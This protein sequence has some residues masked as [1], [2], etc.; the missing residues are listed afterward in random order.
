MFRYLRKFIEA[1]LQKKMVFLGGPRQ[2]GKTTLA[3][4]LGTSDDEYFNWDNDEQRKAILAKRWKA[5]ASLII[6]DELHKYPHWKSWIK[7]VWDVKTS[8]QRFLVTGSA[9]LDVYQKSGDSLVGRYHYWRLHPFTL[10]EYPEG[11]SQ[12][13]VYERLLK[14]GGFPEPFLSGDEREAR[15]WRRERLRRVLQED[16]RDISAV[17]QLQ[18][19]DLFMECLRDRA[20]SLL[21]LSNVAQ[22]LQISP[23]TAKQWL[24]IIERLYLAFPIYPYTKNIPRSIQKPAKIYFYD[25]ADVREEEGVRL[26][27][28]VATH[29]LKRLHFIEDY[30]GYDCQLYYLRDK[31]GREVD[32]VTVIDR[33]IDELIEV[34]LSDESP[35]TSLKYYQSK[36]N[37]RRAVQLVGSLT[38]SFDANGIHVTSPLEYFSKGPWEI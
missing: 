16:S 11:F 28:L 30:Y 14:V 21:A 1:D 7:G 2:V 37:P 19:L 17:Q 4:T 34:K 32:F 36:L 31:D 29:L 25:N 22:D 23:N 8:S 26:E 5:S 9:R 18:S 38:R 27:N 24:K 20:G 12:K 6:F 33:K 10:D 13:E 3:K 15:R 35:T